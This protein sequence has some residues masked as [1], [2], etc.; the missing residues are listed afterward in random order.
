[1]IHRRRAGVDGKGHEGIEMNKAGLVHTDPGLKGACCPCGGQGDDTVDVR[2]RGQGRAAV[3]KGHR[4]IVDHQHDQTLVIGGD[5]FRKG[6][7]AGKGLTGKSHLN[8]RAHRS[9]DDRKVRAVDGETDGSAKTKTRHG[10]H[11]DLGRGRTADARGGQFKGA[12]S[13]GQGHQA[14]AAA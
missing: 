4:C 3:C 2:D 10:V 7:D 6:K 1:M 13:P 9:G 12:R 8:R 14:G 5:G 11:R